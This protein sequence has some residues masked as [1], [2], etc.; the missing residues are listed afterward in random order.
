MDLK[1]NI[2]KTETLKNNVKTIN[3]KINEIIVRGG[4][5]L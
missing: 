4:F 5:N 1:Q 2:N 3:N